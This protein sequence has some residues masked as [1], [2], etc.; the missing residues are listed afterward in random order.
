M[1]Q[2]LATLVFAAA[3][4]TS[5]CMISAL[6]AAEWQ[7]VRIA[8]GLAGLNDRS[9]LPPRIRAMP[10]RRVLMLRVAPGSM[11]YAA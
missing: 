3:A 2:S 10:A 9:P 4:L 8:L 5:L 1:M 6:I 7:N 11:R